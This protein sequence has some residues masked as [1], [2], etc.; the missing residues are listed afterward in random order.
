[1]LT[2]AILVVAWINQTT[3]W[4]AVPWLTRHRRQARQ[5]HS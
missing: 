3:A 4:W 1:M 2:P 5:G